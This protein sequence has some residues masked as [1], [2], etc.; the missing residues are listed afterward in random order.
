MR[1]LSP[2]N[3]GFG[4]LHTHSKR[5][6]KLY[7]KRFQK[8]IEQTA[9]GSTQSTSQGIRPNDGE[10]LRRGLSEASGNSPNLPVHLQGGR[11]DSIEPH[12]P[13]KG[14][15]EIP[16]QPRHEQYQRE[17]IDGSA[18]DE[19]IVA[20]NV[21]YQEGTAPYYNLFY[22]PDVP[23]LNAGRLP[24]WILKK[25]AHIEAGGW[26]CSGVD[27]ATGSD[28]LWGCFKPDQPRID[29][30]KGK[31]QKYEHPYKAP[32]TLFALRVPDEIWQKIASRYGAD[33]SSTDIDHF[34]SDRGFWKWVI[35]N[36]QIDVVLTEGAKKAGSLLAQGFAALG[37]PGI[38]GGYRKNDGNPTLIPQLKP[39]TGE[40]RNFYFAFDQDEKRKTRFS[41]RKALWSTARLLINE[42]SS[43]K[44]TSWEPWLKG[45]DDLIVA[46]GAKHFLS[47]YQKS[48]RFE[49]WQADSL[50]ELTYPVAL[51]L[52]SNTKYIGDFAPPPNAK[53]ICI[54]APKGSGKTEWLV[55]ICTEAQ[56]RGQKVLVLTH[57]TQLG[58]ALCERFG[59]DYVTEIGQSETKGIFGFGLCFDSL[60]LNSQ[61]RFDPEDWE[62]CLVILDE[63]EQSIWHLLNAN[64][65]VAKHRVQI[66]RNFQQLIQNVLSS[67]E[68]KVYLSDADLSD[69][70]L[71]YIK[72]LCS[73]PVEPWIVVKEGNPDPWQ[74]T[75]WNDEKEMLDVL[76]SRIRKGEKVLIFVDGQ[77]AKSKWGTQNLEAYFYK[78]IPFLKILRIDAESV[79]TPT[80]SAYDCIDKLDRTLKDFNICIASPTIET[81]VSID[82]KGHFT[83][84]WDFAQGVIPVPSVLQRMARLRESVPR[85]VWAKSYGLGRIGNGSTSPKHLVAGQHN[86]FK[87]HV[88]QLAEADFIF[89]WESASSFQ[90]QALKTWTKM[91]GRINLGMVRYRHE[92]VRAL[93]AEG[94]I[95]TEGNYESEML[96][97]DEAKGKERIKEELKECRD[98]NYQAQRQAIADSETPDNTRLKSLQEKQVKTDS[99]RLEQRK[100]ELAERYGSGDLV[101][102]ELVELDDLGEYSKAQLHY[103]LTEGE[104]FLNERERSRIEHLLEVGANEL[105]LPDTNK[106]LIGGKLAYLKVLGIPLLFENK[107]WTND[108]TELIDLSIL[109]KQFKTQIKDVLGLSFNFDKVGKDGQPLPPSPVSI[110]QRYLRECL[111][112]KFSDPVKRGAK[113][114]QQRFYQPVVVPELRHQ[115]FAAWKQ[116][117]QL[118][119]AT[120]LAEETATTPSSTKAENGGNG[121]V[122]VPVS[123]VTV[124]STGNIEYIETAAYQ[125]AAYQEPVRALGDFGEVEVSAAATSTAKPENGSSKRVTVPVSS[126]TVGSTG[127]IE[128]R[129][130]VAY[131]SAAYQEPVSVSGDSGDVEGEEPKTELELLIDRL[132]DCREIG[133]FEEAIAGH[134]R[135]QVEN[136]FLWQELPHKQMCRGW[137]ASIQQTQS[138]QPAFNQEEVTFSR[139]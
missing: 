7:G 80:H 75:V 72:S 79:S 17:W 70:S 54:K 86:K 10:G 11:E 105:F 100:G 88:K 133:E 83:S 101:T 138:S 44:I 39:F 37:L 108:S 121:C 82:L 66:L 107:E 56:H 12:S 52:D 32:A 42:G 28:D 36:P 129:N 76:L 29:S 50:R 34:S 99:E 20:L 14:I 69:V 125:P 126:V 94:H 59:I 132:A 3:K 43:V 53:L 60:R 109:T 21:E 123:S 31:Y 87:A 62:D 65:E 23:R 25:Y 112:L 120:K 96:G 117:D 67:E 38:W 51:R 97:E 55:K 41:N 122:T 64:T 116:R 136:A 127:N 61:A 95:V 93:V 104:E 98:I 6:D 47:C 19:R 84:V 57:R 135:E 15:K 81:G 77:K 49:D 103:Y 110:A 45:V 48:L 26:W 131:Q 85:H 8:D 46:K 89:D 58:T 111:G 33:F 71:D 35:K 115:L 137:L 91:A 9:G 74:V 4:T 73:F 13:I 5:K 102:A 78:E 106:G 113:G 114:N 118:R 16:G 40:G 124:G 128:Y 68:G 63:C 1:A 22:S 134:T 2:N 90:P 92:I 27:P 119:R 130:T 30:A 24:G 18:V 139:R